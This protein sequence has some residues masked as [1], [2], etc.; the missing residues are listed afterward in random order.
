MHS[1]FFYLVYKLLNNN[2]YFYG[3]KEFLDLLC[4]NLL[5]IHDSIK[6]NK[7]DYSNN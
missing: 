3:L 6:F 1:T 4:K 5:C 2:W 7:K